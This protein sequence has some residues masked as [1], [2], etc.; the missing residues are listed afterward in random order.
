MPDSDQ[1]NLGLLLFIPYRHLESVVLATLR[2]HGH[3]L[4]LS[5]ARVFQR[6]APTGSRMSELAEASQLTKQTVTSIV[7]Q[8][9]HAGYVVRRP[10]PADARA[11]V[12][13]ITESGQELVALSRPVVAEVE[14]SWRAHLGDADTDELRRLLARLREITDP[15]RVDSRPNP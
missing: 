9:E 13:R 4:S 6:I 11:R 7:D 3:P 8:L 2:A 14:A 15:F 10:D 12:V 1:L 5:Q